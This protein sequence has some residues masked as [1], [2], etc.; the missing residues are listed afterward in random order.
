MTLLLSILLGLFLVVSSLLG[1]ALV[2][3]RDESVK[4]EVT[5]AGLR[6]ERDAVRAELE[7]YRAGEAERGALVRSEIESLSNRI[8]EEKAGKFKELGTVAIAGLVGP[9]RE[10]LEKLQKALVE[11]ETKD[12]VREQSLR[13]ALER[14]ASVN[15]QLGSQADHLARALS[16]DNKL[17]GDFGEEI[18]ARLLEHSG[19]KAGIDYVEQGEELE[20]RGEAG[21]R[22]LPDVVIF[23]PENRCLVVDS[24]MS[25]KSWAESHSD[26]AAVRIAGLAAFRRSVR[27]HVDNLASKPYT[28][29]LLTS[30]RGS[31]DFKFLFVPIES[32]FHACLQQDRD[33]YRYAFERRIILVSPTTLLAALVTVNH[34]WKQFEIGRNAQAIRDRAAMLLD[35]LQDFFGSMEKVG[36]SLG[37]A[38][39][40]YETARKRL[41]TG[42]GNLVGQARKL[43]ELKVDSTKSIPLSLATLASDDED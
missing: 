4:L 23:L 40:A 31:I 8:F 37:K 20:L 29:A 3:S 43:K 9:V 11:S 18:L 30:G 12:A 28:E 21:G 41:A 39:E 6:A 25:L 38:Q 2:R 42:S 13:E 7:R 1:W 19:L 34:T 14:V 22:L 26:D 36:E 35:K 5:S 33:L 27:A 32:A 10:N 15:A 24:K 16:S 17:V